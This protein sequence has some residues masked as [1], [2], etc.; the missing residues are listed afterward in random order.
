[1]NVGDTVQHVSGWTA[2]V[3]EITGEV[4][5]NRAVYLAGRRDPF[6]ECV[7]TVLPPAQASLAAI[8]IREAVLE[9]LGLAE[10]DL[11]TGRLTVQRG[12]DGVWR[13]D[14]A[15]SMTHD[16]GT[17]AVQPDGSF[18]ILLDPTSASADFDFDPDAEGQ[19]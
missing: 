19:A 14:Y 16:L 9:E 13:W 2:K 15:D 1:M 6:L 3:A 18:K 8:R 4:A 17:V 5:G 12:E 7:L 10:E 11:G